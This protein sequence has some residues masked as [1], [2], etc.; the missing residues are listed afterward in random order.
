M[1]LGLENLVALDSTKLTDRAIDRADELGRC[2]RPRTVAQRAR[3]KVI[4]GSV[5]GHIGVGRFGHID[6]V[7]PDKPADDAGR[8]ATG[9]GTGQ[10]AGQHGEGLLGNQV[11]R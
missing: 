9:A 2:E 1:S 3:E 7:A 10:L 11:L 5:S 8:Q 4:E 6:A